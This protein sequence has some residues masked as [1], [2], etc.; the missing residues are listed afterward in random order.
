MKCLCKE[1]GGDVEPITIRRTLQRI[2][3]SNGLFVRM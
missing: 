1:V 2:V 3:V